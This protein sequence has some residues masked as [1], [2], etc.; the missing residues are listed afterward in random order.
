MLYLSLAPSLLLVLAGHLA[1]CPAP[2]PVR[3]NAFAACGIVCVI[4]SACAGVFL[5]TATLLLLGSLSVALWAWP[6]VRTRTRSFLPL[7]VLAFVGAYAAGVLLSLPTLIEYARLRERY[8]YESMADRVPVP[9]ATERVVAGH[10]AVSPSEAEL[11]VEANS[12]GRAGKQRAYLLERLH[13]DTT[14]LFVNSPG[15]GMARMVNTPSELGL[16]LLPRDDPPDQPR[17]RPS[18]AGGRSLAADLDAESL[19][20]RSV[21]DFVHPAGFGFVKD[22]RR[23]AGFQPHGFSRVPDPPPRY[24]V[25]TV[26]LVGLLL[27]PEPVVYVSPRLPA[28]ADLR[29]APTR[30]LDAFESA[31]LAAVRA[32]KDLHTAQAGGRV[33][34]VGALRNGR[35]C[36]QCH[37]GD[38]G[39]LLGA[40]S[41]SLR[42]AGG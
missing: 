21:V 31:G 24:S 38:E 15:F 3:W 17:P 28:M 8:P 14:R 37:G 32:G 12:D 33:R 7:S 5:P 1:A 13:E 22:R 39:D 36:V 11:E 35:R 34:M 4:G 30:P 27:H 6:R 41:Y 2:H 29:G 26:E 20:T 9:K 25:E 42:A 40:F 18:D 19:H 16:K 23:V 10:T